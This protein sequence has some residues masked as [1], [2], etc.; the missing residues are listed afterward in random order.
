MRPV[1]RRLQT[2]V[3]QPHHIVERKAIEARDEVEIGGFAR[4]VLGLGDWLGA[5]IVRIVEPPTD[6]DGRAGHLA[7]EQRE[8]GID[9]GDRAGL[10]AGA[11]H[12]QRDA[13]GEDDVEDLVLQQLASD[14]GA[15]GRFDRALEFGA[16]DGVGLDGLDPRDVAVRHLADL[17]VVVADL[18]RGLAV[19]VDDEQ[20]VGG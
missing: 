3:D 6:G 12:A 1:A 10:A 17:R 11:V 5:E 15:D 18:D 20:D 4:E 16:R 13:L 8:F 7:V 2:T 14:P 9:A 19:V